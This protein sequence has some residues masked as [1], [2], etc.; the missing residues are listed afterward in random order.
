MN[1]S[2]AYIIYNWVHKKIGKCHTKERPQISWKES[3]F[4]LTISVIQRIK[5]MEST[6][7]SKWK[8]ICT[9]IP[10]TGSLHVS[11]HYL[12]LL[13]KN[14]KLLKSTLVKEAILFLDSLPMLAIE[15]NKTAKCS[16]ARTG[17]FA[18]KMGE[19]ST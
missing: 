8:M 13:K 4:L 11:S 16:L 3:L 18:G 1:L 10:C 12:E 17:R 15:K 19:M 14:C 5:I 7:T 6:S 9:M 2:I